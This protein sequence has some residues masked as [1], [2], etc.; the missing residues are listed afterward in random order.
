MYQMIN[1]KQIW[2]I[3]TNNNYEITGSHLAQALWECG[4]EKLVCY[5]LR[6]SLFKGSI[7]YPCLI[8][9]SGLY[10]Q[11]LRKDYE[12]YIDNVHWNSNRFYKHEQSELV[13]MVPKESTTT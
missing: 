3:V 12:L 7:S 4:G 11:R 9:I 10:K 8:L 13:K 5:C 1:E 6:V 2:Y